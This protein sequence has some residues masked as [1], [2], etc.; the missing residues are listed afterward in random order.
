MKSNW[1]ASVSGKIICGTVVATGAT[2]EAA[3]SE[4]RSA[5]DFHLDGLRDDGQK[6]PLSN[7]IE[8]SEMNSAKSHML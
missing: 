4:L 3:I 6:V 5:L 8:L 1:C 7:E 2:R